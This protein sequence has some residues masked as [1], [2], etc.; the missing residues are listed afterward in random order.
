MLIYFPILGD[1]K[2]DQERSQNT[3]KYADLTIEIQ[4]M[5]NVKTRDTSNNKGDKI[6]TRQEFCI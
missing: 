4:C 6:T 1:Q 5:W 3:L 2:C